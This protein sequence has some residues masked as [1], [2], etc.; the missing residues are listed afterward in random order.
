MTAAA[1]SNFSDADFLGELLSFEEF[2]EGW[3]W[4]SAET[5]TR[6]HYYRED[7]SKTLHGR[8]GRVKFFVALCGTRAAANARL[9]FHAPGEATRCARC[10]RSEL[11][12]KGGA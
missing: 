1:A 8:Y 5:V 10:S 2:K 6:A 12:G 11:A 7:T 4:A 3:A 9:P